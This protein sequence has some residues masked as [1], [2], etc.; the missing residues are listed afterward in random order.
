M[1][2]RPDS[3]KEVA[4]TTKLEP[5]EYAIVVSASRSVIANISAVLLDGGSRTFSTPRHVGV[6]P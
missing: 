6:V 1:F 4:L 3:P 2:D 5:P